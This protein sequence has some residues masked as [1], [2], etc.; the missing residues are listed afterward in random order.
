MGRNK[1]MKKEERKKKKKEERRS[2]RGAWRASSLAV[3]KKA[4]EKEKK[5]RGKVFLKNFL[6]H[7]KPY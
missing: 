5:E 7:F 3:E 2:V 4:R 6:I 1:E